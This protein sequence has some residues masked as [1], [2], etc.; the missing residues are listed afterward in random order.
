MPDEYFED[1][2]GYEK[3]SWL[4]VWELLGGVAC[5]WVAVSLPYAEFVDAAKDREYQ[6][7][8]GCPVDA[9]TDKS[10]QFK[11]GYAG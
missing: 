11:H 10:N 4:V 3:T 7:L 6:V 2:G 5:V 9:W 8:G 1:E